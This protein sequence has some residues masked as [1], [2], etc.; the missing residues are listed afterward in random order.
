[1]LRVK[2]RASDP[3]LRLVKTTSSRSAATTISF[4]YPAY[5][6]PGFPRYA[7]AF[8]SEFVANKLSYL[9]FGF[10]KKVIHFELGHQLLPLGERFQFATG[11]LTQRWERSCMKND[12]LSIV[13]FGEREAIINTIF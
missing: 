2:S 1:M 5:P 10:R 13:L 9:P 4:S 11:I 12:Q 7:V 3:V 6:Y 8:D